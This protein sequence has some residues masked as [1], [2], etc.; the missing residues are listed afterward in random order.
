ME[1][2]RNPRGPS[3]AGIWSLFKPRQNSDSDC[4]SVLI[5]ITLSVSSMR[6][7]QNVCLSDIM[8]QS[9]SGEPSM[10]AEAA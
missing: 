9:L 4:E 1:R 10:I 3:L 5:L 2:L 8:F 6:Y 7:N